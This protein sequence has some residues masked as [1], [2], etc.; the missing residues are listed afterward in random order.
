MSTPP[1]TPSAP[2]PLPP[3]PTPPPAP[4][5]PPPPPPPPSTSSSSSSSTSPS[6]NATATSLSDS[7]AKSA[8]KRQAKEMKSEVTLQWATQPTSKNKCVRIV[9]MSDTHNHVD[10]L[11]VPPGDILIHCGDF[12]N[13][14]LVQRKRK[15]KNRK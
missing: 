6:T 12:T 1:E 5:S 15:G 2:P 7:I 4:V 14:E 13:K 10:D 8:E 9:V 3:S 11:T